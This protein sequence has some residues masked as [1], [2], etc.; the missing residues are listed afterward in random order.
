MGA[1]SLEFFSA[2]EVP[3][4]A[5]P[6][7]D[8]IVSAEQAELI[9]A[10]E[11]REFT[12]HGA[13]EALEHATGDAPSAEHVDEL[14]RRAYRDG[15]LEL[16]DESYERFRVAT[17]YDRLGVFVI[18]QASD[19][20]SL[21]A[22]TR[23]ALDEWFFDAYA[24]G[25]PDD[26][27]PTG[28]RVLTLSQT[29]ARIDETDQPI[30]LNPCDCR[31]L[32]GHCELPVDTCVTFRNGIN[33]VSHRGWSK[34]LTKAQAKAIVT[35]ADADGLMHTV[36]DS[37]ICNC[38]SDCCY[39]FRA[40]AARGSGAVWPLAE[41]IAALDT[42][43]CIGCELCLRRCPFDAFSRDGAAVALDPERC[44][45]CGLCAETCPSDAIE[46]RQR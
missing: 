38:C 35:Q 42:D 13:R 39:L 17:F 2:F 24:A 30:W 11:S 28:D 7:I 25:L 14:L 44:R 1:S 18:A 8:R 32:A 33:T 21:P 6:V 9:G 20:L 36:N 45:G 40:Q 4:V 34:P 12:A 29:L 37:G 22:E 3:R 5:T 31:T 23:T 19:Y 15:V 41:Q 10:L 43:A 26:E 16:L 27:R 46:M